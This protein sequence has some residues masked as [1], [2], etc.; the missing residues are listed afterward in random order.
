[1]NRLLLAAILFVEIAILSLSGVIVA[2]GELNQGALFF[3]V[4]LGASA[5]VSVGAAF[6]LPRR[7]SGRTATH[8]LLLVG[9]VLFI[10]PFVWLMGTSFKY[11]EEIYV[12]PPKW[13]PSIP[14][15]HP[16]SPYVTAELFDEPEAPQG[17]G[18]DR[19]KTLWPKAAEALWEEGK[20][21]IPADRLA[22]LDPERVKDVVTRGLWDTVSPGVRVS[23]WKEDDAAVMKALVERVDASRMDDV[24]RQ[25][26]RAVTLRVPFAADLSRSEYALTKIDPDALTHWHAESD[27]V[28]L[29]NQPFSLTA[30]EFDAVLVHYDLSKDPA[31][32]IAGVFPLPMPASEFLS[33]TLPIHQ[34]RSWNRFEVAVDLDGKRYVNEDLQCLQVYLGQELTFKLKARD[35]R[36]ERSQGVWT[37]VE[38]P[39]AKNPFSEPG[40]FRVTV[41]IHR[42][43]AL[44]G[45]WYKYTQNYRNAWVM[46]THWNRYLFNSAYLV[47]L[48]I[49]GQML[50]CS[51]VAYAFARLRWPGRDVLFLIVLGTMMLPAQVTMIPVFLIFKQVGWYN[52]LKPLWVPAFLGTPFFIFMLRQFMKSIPRTLEEAA[53]IDGCGYFGTYRQVILPLTKP[54][55]AA[56][57]IFTF[58]GTWNEFMAPLIFLSDQRLYPLALGLFDLRAEYG[59]DFGMLMAASTIMVLPVVGLF[60]FAQ[61]YFIEGVTLTG[62]KN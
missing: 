58:M 34:D 8:G 35:E 53:R 4:L 43:S 15:G 23:V 51:L 30:E 37:L 7:V 16:R 13:I 54:A 59:G 44:E 20:A 6:G 10:F 12:Y 46:G 3:A 61:R 50:S 38:D 26:Y 41:L 2:E 22:D 40:K 14:G 55:L 33:I 47:V 39:D 49:I 25:A 36:D 24:W 18:R 29:F 45:V 27:N 52:T 9:C 60:F 1:M 11:S 31:A 57:G 48:T 28:Q 56:V 21:F 17:V 62:M 5:A 19:W 32:E 42:S